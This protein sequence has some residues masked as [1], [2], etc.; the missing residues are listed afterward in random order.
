V[1]LVVDTITKRFGPVTALLLAGKVLGTGAAG[2]TQYG[3]I[4]VAGVGFLLQGT[5][6]QRILGDEAGASGATGL[7]VPLLIGIGA[8]F[9]RP[10]L[11][12]VWRVT[13]GQRR[14]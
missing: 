5:L 8:F 11:R 13:F 2:L 9:M 7:T 10:T 6:T 1:S 12:A 14:A 4:L 3:A